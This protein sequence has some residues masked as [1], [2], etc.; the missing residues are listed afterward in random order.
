[1]IQ[2]SEKEFY[3]LQNGELPD[4]KPKLEKFKQATFLDKPH[5][6]TRK[7]SGATLEALCDAIPELIG[8]SADLTGSVC[9]KTSK[10]TSITEE[11][12]SGRYLHYGVREHAM[13]AIMNGLA[14]HKGLIPY[15]GT[16]LVFF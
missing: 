11:N 12:F 4:F 16:F 15:A 5:Q 2:N 13:G 9:T 14:L 8:G 3:R 1:M 7:S 10:M 6:A